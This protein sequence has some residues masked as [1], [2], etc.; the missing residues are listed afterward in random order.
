MSVSEEDD[1][2]D[3][4]SRTTRRM[5]LLRCSRVDFFTF[6]L[7]GDE[8]RMI[9]RNCV[10]AVLISCMRADVTSLDGVESSVMEERVDEVP[11]AGARVSG[12]SA[13]IDVVDLTPVVLAGV[14]VSVLLP[15][16]KNNDGHNDGQILQI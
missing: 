3:E 10:I 2:D 9:E 7:F 11:W 14:G 12:A 6:S 4:S 15:S 1:D 13:G 5:W 8:P 16:L